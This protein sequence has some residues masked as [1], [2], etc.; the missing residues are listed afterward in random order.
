MSQSSLQASSS[1][2][3][4]VNASAVTDGGSMQL[5]VESSPVA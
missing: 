1:Q 4:E 3:V 2:T 5:Q